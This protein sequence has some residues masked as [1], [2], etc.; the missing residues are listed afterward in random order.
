MNVLPPMG[1]AAG[2]DDDESQSVPTSVNTQQDAVGLWDLAEM[3]VRP[4]MGWAAGLAEE[5]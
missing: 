5:C 4:P 2:H 1:W 3:N